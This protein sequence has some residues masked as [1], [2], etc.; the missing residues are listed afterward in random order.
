MV[1]GLTLAHTRKHLYRS[2]LESVGYSVAQIF[3]VFREHHIIPEKI[4]A[5]GGGIQ[6]RPWMQIVADIV[7]VTL[8][9]PKII[10][11]ASYGD[12]LMAAL[13]AGY[14]KDF[15]ELESV[16]EIADEVKPDKERHITYQKY[17]RLYTELYKANRDLMHQI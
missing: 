15:R 16:I 2:A 11:G 3:D 9:I 7:G 17:L 14:F 13:S 1:F 5:M 10:V 12:A 6:N 4:M 8:N